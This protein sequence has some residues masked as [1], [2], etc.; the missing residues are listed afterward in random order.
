MRLIYVI[1]VNVFA[2][3]YYVPKM[4]HYAKHPEKY[5]REQRYALAQRVIAKVQ[6]S[7]RISTEVVGEE[8]LPL[9]GGY[10]MFANHQGRYDAIGVIG[11]HKRPCSMLIDLRRYKL[12]IMK[13]AVDLLEGES[14]DKTSS[15][16]QINALTNIANGVKEGKTFLVFPEGIYYKKQGNKTNEFKRGV[17][18]AAI[19]AKCP[20]VP[21]TVVDS[22]RVFG[23]NSLK[24]VKTKVIFHEPIP[25][26]VY[27]DM[28][29]QDIAK[30]V[31]AIIDAELEKH[32]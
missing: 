29:A 11:S 3:I 9:T 22:Y 14:I 30:M 1:L 2:I 28:K 8:N 32:K 25:Y 21:V 6:K 16:S 31:R 4:S 13:Q 23:I 15:R 18:L 10:M 17:F 26:E 20:I 12:F 24:P 7:G 27:K 19:K 5:S